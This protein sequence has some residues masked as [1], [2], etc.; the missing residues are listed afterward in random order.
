[1]RGGVCSVCGPVQRA[2]GWQEWHAAHNQESR[3]QRGYGTRW[4]RLRAYILARD[5]GLCRVCGRP[6]SE[7]DHIVPKSRGGTDDEDNLQTICTACHAQKTAR[8]GLAG[9]GG[10]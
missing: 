8:E 4:Y 9:V 2:T 5:S 1:M 7:V 10:G 6:A 3:H